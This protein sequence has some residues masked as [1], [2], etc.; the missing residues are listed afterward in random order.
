MLGV[1]LSAH[2]SDYIPEKAYKVLPI[3]L[4]ETQRFKTGFD[5]GFLAASI[6]QESCI[7][8]RHS[9][10]WSTTSRFK[11]RWKNG[12][13][14]EEGAG[15]VMLTRTWYRAGGIRFDTLGRLT[16][17]Y[18]THLKGL[19]WST[20]YKE[21]SA[22]LQVRAGMFLFM[23]NWNGLSSVPPCQRLPMVSS[24]YNQGMGG[25]RQD[26]RICGLRRG[27]DPN[28]W[29][30]HVEKV[31]RPGFGTRILYGKR[32]AHQINRTHVRHILKDRMP[33]YRQYFKQRGVVK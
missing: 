8:L 13:N 11:T 21:S 3:I 30:G 9:R 32:T 7:S 22:R 20:V 16:R 10:C 25:I 4:E 1:S 23:D 29:F 15:L 24:A 6:E 19:T 17:K 31:R 14:R 26:R 28:K 5:P 2:A 27:C 12:R 33:K 18:R